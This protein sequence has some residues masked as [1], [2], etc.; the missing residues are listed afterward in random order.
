MN[1]RTVQL[2]CLAIG[3][4]VLI[5]QYF[6]IKGTGK[7]LNARLSGKKKN[8]KVALGL[9]AFLAMIGLGYLYLG[10]W[11]RFLFYLFGW[12]IAF[13]TGFPKK[14]EYLTILFGIWIFTLYDGYERA[15]KTHAPD[16][17][18]PRP[19]QT[20]FVYALMLLVPSVLAAIYREFIK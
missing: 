14:G 20:W 13:L 15:K 1:P 12:Q 10:E 18:I 7:F 9:N 3:W 4:F 8:P 2:I 19:K 5:H 16:Y 17:V 6:E 11:K